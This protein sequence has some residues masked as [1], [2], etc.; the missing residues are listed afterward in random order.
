MKNT[1]WEVKQRRMLH[2]HVSNRLI[3]PK[4]YLQTT[5]EKTSCDSKAYFNNKEYA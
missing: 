5:K 2:E 4:S 3:D 1:D